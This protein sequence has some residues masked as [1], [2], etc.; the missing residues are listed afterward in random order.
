MYF[1]GAISQDGDNFQDFRARFVCD[2]PRKM[3]QLLT[4]RNNIIAY[5][6]GIPYCRQTAI[7]LLTAKRQHG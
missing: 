7:Q 6:G 2:W 3:H 1:I 5:Q 4:E